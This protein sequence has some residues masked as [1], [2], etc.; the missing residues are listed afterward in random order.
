MLPALYMPSD[1]P[2]LQEVHTNL[3]RLLAL[4]DQDPFSPT[5]GIGDR[6]Y[7]SWKL[8]DFG[9]G[10]FQGAVHGLARLVSAKALP[11]W[12]S[13][14]SILKRIDAMIMAARRLMRRDGSLEE[15]FPYESSF[16]VTALVAYDL[17]SCIALL[18][19]RLSAE[20]EERWLD[21]VAPMIDFLAR[22]DETHALISNHLATAVAALLRWHDLTGESTDARAHELLNRIL[23]HASSE[24]WFKE[25]DGADP[26]YQTLALYYLADVSALKPEW[27]LSSVLAKACEFLSYFVHPDGSFGGPYGSRDTRFF[28]PGGIEWLAHS[29]PAAAAV[30]IA[31]RDSIA[32]KRTVTLSAIDESNLVPFFNAYCKAAIDFRG[33]SVPALKL[34]CLTLGPWRNVFPE[35]GLLIE[36]GKHGYTVMSWHKGGVVCHFT[37][38]GTARVACA[39]VVRDPS[40]RLYSA[41]HSVTDNGFDVEKD[42]VIVRA[43]LRPLRHE[44]PTPSRFLV[45]RVLNLT[46]MRVR[47]AG[48]IIKQLLVRFLITGHGKKV[49]SVVR[50]IRFA[51]CFTVED[52]IEG[53]AAGWEQQTKTNPYA[54]IHMASRGYWQ[55][56]DDC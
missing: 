15:A 55:R 27:G 31:M 10:T 18:R 34:P 13:E 44:L 45:L 3:P 49:G 11:E 50:T 41:Q 6:L 42:A 1:N 22:A 36:R 25:Y 17:L 19:G 37:K 24:G 4:F 47:S 35:A 54:V 43:Q 46:V 30:A 38:D 9:N 40:G 14:A 56:G 2:Y 21:V 39:P 20:Q 53:R 52:Q 32:E 5:L 51:P 26:G 29:V 8:K 33:R 12:L 28:C 7:W 23:E 48:E 16:C